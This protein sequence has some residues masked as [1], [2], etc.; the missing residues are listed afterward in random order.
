[1]EG[2][3]STLR[4]SQ[5]ILA[6]SSTPQRAPGPRVLVLRHLDGQTSD[7]GL[8]PEGPEEKLNVRM[9][10]KMTGVCLL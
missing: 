5:V 6:S 4:L 1:M 8:L 9:G 3:V 7:G 2:G 10:N